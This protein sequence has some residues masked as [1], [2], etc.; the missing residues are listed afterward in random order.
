MAT[1]GVLVDGLGE[2]EYLEYD[3][4]D[5][6]DGSSNQHRDHPHLDINFVHVIR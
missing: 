6:D 5:D 2:H 3:E 1:A 4:D